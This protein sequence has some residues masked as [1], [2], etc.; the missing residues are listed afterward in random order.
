MATVLVVD[1]ESD[2]RELLAD[3]LLDAGFQVI[4]AANGES[5]LAR[6]SRDQPDIML[7][8][9]S[10]PGMDGFEVLWRLK[11]DP[12]TQEL[13]V[14]LLTAVP[15][16]EGEKMGMDLGIKHYICKPWEPGVV[17]AVVRVALAEETVSDAVAQEVIKVEN[18]ILDGKLGGGIPLGSLSLIEGESSAGKSVLCQQLTYGALLGRRCIAY[19][20]SEST[21]EAL[22]PQMASIGLKVSSYI[23]NGNLR[24]DQLEEPTAD[25][26][27][28]RVMDELVENIEELP[29]RYRVIV[30]DAITNLAAYS[31]E[32]TITRFFS[33]CKRLCAEGRTIILV[34]HSQAF[35]EKLLIRL[36]A[37]CDTHLRLSV[38]KVGAKLVKSLEVCKIRNAQAI[39]GD[40][41]NFDVEPGLGIRVSPITRVRG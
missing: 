39:T 23:R 13:P 40:I 3:T 34:A 26:D 29:N 36:G 10:M 30:V 7:L 41:V 6:A 2:I 19:F 15:A 4:E 18:E 12:Y 37:L 24:I 11:E 28:E 25:T 31:E 16:Y 22:V 17:E 38:E 33:S 8:D 1:D 35:E 20:T 21:A 32:K 14:I 5:A 27:P 9:I